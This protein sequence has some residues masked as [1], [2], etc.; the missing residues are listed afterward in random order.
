MKNLIHRSFIGIT[1]LLSTACSPSPDAAPNDAPQKGGSNNNAGTHSDAGSSGGSSS[2]DG[3]APS[4]PPPSGPSNGSGI[5]D[6]GPQLFLWRDKIYTGTD[7]Q[8]G[9]VVPIAAS[10]TQN[11]G[12]P[13]P[14]TTPPSFTLADPTL[15]S[16]KIVPVPS[17][18]EVQQ[19][20]VLQ[21]S[22][23]ALITPA[24]A[25]QTILTV[26]YGG[27]TV[28]AGLDVVTYTPADYTLG[29]TRYT[30]PTTPGAQRIACTTCHSATSDAGVN[31]PRHDPFLQQDLSDAQL[32]VI[33]EKGLYDA[34][35]PN[36]ALQVPGGHTWN[37]TAAEETGIPAYVRSLRPLGF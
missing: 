21:A 9:Y 20:P 18:P 25:G 16:I 15:A 35:N 3:G 32:L 30:N 33:I 17:A 31:A 28:K 23:F 24:K 11:D 6:A 10:L 29:Q 26:T 4:S 22:A 8:H 14:F 2:A 13:I 34:N 37:L 5:T 27:Q 19:D 1:L 7:G 36:S 12:T